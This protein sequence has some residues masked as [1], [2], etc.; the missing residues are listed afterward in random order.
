MK[1][2]ITGVSGFVG[3][4]LVYFLQK[5]P[6]Y[7]ILGI[8]KNQDSVNSKIIFKKCDLISNKDEL[9]KIF[10]EFKPDIVIHCA[11]KILDTYDKDLVWKTNYYVTKD[12]IEISSKHNVKRISTG[13]Y[14]CNSCDYQFASGAYYPT[15]ED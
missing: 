15:R 9:N 6:K 8:D 12:L 1:F 11:S 3:E 5:N 4:E 10:N 7:T 14:K 13:I 2:L